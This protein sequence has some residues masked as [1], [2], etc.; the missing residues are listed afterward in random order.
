MTR[1]ARATL[2]RARRSR[3][4]VL[5]AM[6]CAALLAPATAGA[7]PAGSITGS[8]AVPSGTIA[9][10]DITIQL[11]DRN[12]A[13]VNVNPS[14]VVITPTS[15]TTAS[16]TISAVPAGQY[17]LYFSD[18]TPG[19]NVAPDYYGDGGTDNV[20]RATAVTVTG[21]GTQALATEP[22]APGA[23]VTGSVNDANTSA[24]SVA[25]VSARPVDAT[26]V[27][28]PVLAENGVMGAVSGGAYRITGLPTGVFTLT[29]TAHGP[30]GFD[31]RAFAVGGGL[32][33]DSAA[34]TWY[35]IKAGA[36]ATTNL[37]VPRLG[38]ISG[39]L[40][41]AAGNAL[42]GVYV[43]AFDAAGNPAGSPTQTGV[44][45]GYTL[46]DLLPGSYRVEFMGLAASNLA[47]TFHGGS[48]LATATAVNVK[49]G[50]GVGGVDGVLRTGAV[51]SGNV[52]AAQGDAALAGITVDLVDAQGNVV[53]STTSN[54]DGSYTLQYVPA[55]TW[56]LEFVGGRAQDGQSYASEY[57]LNQ[58]SLIGARRFRVR[59][60]QTL[61]HVNGV[62][63]PASPA[64][65]GIPRVALGRLGGVA[66]NRVT[67]SF[68]VLAGSGPAPYVRSFS[69]KLPRLF[70][71]NRG[72]LKRDLAISGDHFRYVIRGG[73]LLVTLRPSQG[74]VNFRIKPGGIRVSRQIQRLAKKRR[75]ASEVVGV[76]I[77]DTTG[78]ATAT[79]FTVTD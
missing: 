29:Y 10:T 60:G 66:H 13:I 21:S 19:D 24:E 1:A 51:L 71:W 44:G 48:E 46:S 47:P 34:A 78:K 76:L 42:D 68:R 61:K 77:T 63:L 50:A 79:S 30:G 53:A 40:R 25:S 31:L 37:S 9:V 39:R 27:P 17:F 12:G 4:V 14:A 33:Y 15:A 73:R 49:A 20:G 6:A 69:I 3:L 11:V 18:S 62:L 70:S 28:D 36:T 54:A 41:D 38:A 75:I 32:T 65:P 23:V 26:S 57:Y 43:R 5:A 2:S 35:S 55:G 8:F 45:G 59:A 72:A 7:Q 64:Q 22:L 67:L 52:T 16:Y 74:L 58:G 56:Y